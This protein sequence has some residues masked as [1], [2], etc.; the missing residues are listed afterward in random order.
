MFSSKS[1]VVLV[2]TFWCMIYGD[3][4]F[5]VRLGIRIHFSARGYHFPSTIWLNENIFECVSIIV[6]CSLCRMS[7][8]SQISSILTP[9]EIKL[10]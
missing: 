7:F 1:S 8:V 3:N 10:K 5:G 9:Y 2:V 6:L 4:S